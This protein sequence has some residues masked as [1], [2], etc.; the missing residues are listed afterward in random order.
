MQL[1]GTSSPTS[2]P[3]IK[4]LYH[5]IIDLSELSILPGIPTSGYGYLSSFE[6]MVISFSRWV[7]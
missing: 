7:R 1:T 5:K 2:L 6:K 4:H 3:G